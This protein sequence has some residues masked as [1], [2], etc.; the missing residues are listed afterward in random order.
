MWIKLQN[1]IADES[2]ATAIEYT[3]I[4]GLIFLALTAGAESMS[5]SLEGIYNYVSDN[6][7]NSMP[8]G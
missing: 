1:L 5:L 8:G 7:S 2:G 6:M 3:L 4:L